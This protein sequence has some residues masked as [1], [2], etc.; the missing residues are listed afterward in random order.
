MEQAAA[1]AP[2]LDLGGT[3]NHKKLLFAVVA[4]GHQYLIY[5]DGTVEGFGDNPCVFN[6]YQLRMNKLWAQ[7]SANGSLEMGPIYWATSERVGAEQ[8]DPL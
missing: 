5:L 2:A 3:E 1:V 7:L 8:A 4:D 6:F